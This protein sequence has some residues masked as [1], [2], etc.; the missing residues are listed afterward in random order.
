MNKMKFNTLILFLFAFSAFFLAACGAKKTVKHYNNLHLES[1]LT[2]PQSATVSEMLADYYYIKD[3]LVATNSGEADR[4]ANK[5]KA[6]VIQLQASFPGNDSVYAV[7][8]Q[9][10]PA[11]MG[12]AN[13]LTE[14]NAML[15]AKNKDCE[16]KRI[17]FKALSDAFYSLLKKAGTRNI[18]AY[19]QYCP[20]AMN[21]QGAYWLSASPEIEN[22]YFG[23]KM[24]TCGELVDTIH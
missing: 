15:A 8:I 6:S 10:H 23:E 11:L 5:M 18:Q 3:A 13:M 1:K 2:K 16:L 24:L 4:A 12:T 22:P 7:F 21:E 19:H 17:H 20:M 9:E 14:L